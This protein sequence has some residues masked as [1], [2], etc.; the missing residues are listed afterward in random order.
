MSFL[1]VCG[2]FFYNSTVVLRKFRLVRHIPEWV[3]WISYWPL[4]R[5]GHALAEQVMNDP[6]RF[7][8][9]SIVSNN[10]CAEYVQGLTMLC[11]AK[12]HCKALH[13]IGPPCRGREIES[14][15]ARRIREGDYGNL[16]DHVYRSVINSPSASYHRLSGANEMNLYSRN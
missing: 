2:S 9:E 7:V 1:S 8:R 3:P 11:A 16:G 14:L 4:A 5:I 6:M 12:W 15:R 10:L 13:C